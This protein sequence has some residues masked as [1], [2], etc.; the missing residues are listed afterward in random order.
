MTTIKA[1]SKLDIWQKKFANRVAEDLVYFDDEVEVDVDAADT[2]L[3]IPGLADAIHEVFGDVIADIFER[4]QFDE[5][6]EGLADRLTDE[7]KSAILSIARDHS[8]EKE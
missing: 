5:T 1:E 8:T 7:Q 2:L 4:A 3:K 6:A